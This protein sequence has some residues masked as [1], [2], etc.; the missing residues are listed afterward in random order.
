MRDRGVS[1]KSAGGTWNVLVYA[2]YVMFFPQLVAGPIERPAHLLH[3][4]REYHHFDV[5][6]AAAGLKRIAW[7]LFKKAVIADRLA[8]L[9]KDVFA[10]PSAFGGFYFTPRGSSLHVPDLLRFFGIF[11]YRRRV[12]ATTWLPGFGGEFRFAF[13]RALDRR[14]LASL[15]HLAVQLDPRLRVYS[16]GRKPRTSL[17]K[18]RAE[19]DDHVYSGAG[20]GTGPVGTSSCGER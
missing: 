2:T 17:G 9:V 6:R 13:L 5:E 12:G 11:G 18:R 3:Q 8:L 14:V 15:A 4:F 7:G 16:V 20:C 1:R 19:L 10:E